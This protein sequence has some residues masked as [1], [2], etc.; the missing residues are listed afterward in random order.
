VSTEVPSGTVTSRT[1][2]WPGG[3]TWVVVAPPGP[4]IVN[5]TGPAA[6]AEAVSV[7]GTLHVPESSSAGPIAAVD[8]WAAGIS[9]S[10][11]RAVAPAVS[12]TSS[13]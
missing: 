13:T 10:Q 7:T 5:S 2:V 6:R 3:T 9:K 1:T 4:V 12:C 11:S 8:R